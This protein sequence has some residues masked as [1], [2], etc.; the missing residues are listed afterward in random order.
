MSFVDPRKRKVF[1][2]LIFAF[3][4]PLAVSC[5]QQGPT[6][7]VD[8][9]QPQRL[10]S[11]RQAA[12]TMMAVRSSSDE[13]AGVAASSKL[14]VFSR[15]ME[16]LTLQRGGVVKVQIPLAESVVSAGLVRGI[17]FQSSAENLKGTVVQGR[18]LSLVVGD[19]AQEGRYNCNLVVKL[20][21]GREFVQS[22]LISV[23]P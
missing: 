17:D 11:D 7:V 23:I 20:E 8:K 12:T 14:Q 6:L 21:N 16:P 9:N 22:M 13:G 3:W 18:T 10:E 15:P 5:G 1:P 4:L 19:D 2:K